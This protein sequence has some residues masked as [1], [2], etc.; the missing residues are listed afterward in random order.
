MLVHTEAKKFDS[1]IILMLQWSLERF[2]DLIET[3]MIGRITF[4]TGVDSLETV[5]CFKKAEKKS[6]SF[7]RP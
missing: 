2:D 1:F 3:E 4:E 7:G 6:C 5:V